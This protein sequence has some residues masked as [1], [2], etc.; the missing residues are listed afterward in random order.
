MADTDDGADAVRVVWNGG[1]ELSL[2][3]EPAA[4]ALPPNWL[5]SHSFPP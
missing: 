3:R 1:E 2:Y 5:L 4:A